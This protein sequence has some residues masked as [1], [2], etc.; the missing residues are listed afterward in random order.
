MAVY[1][2]EVEIEDFEYDEDEEM[3]YYPCP[4]GDRFQISKEELI[5]GEEV[6]TCPS[7]SLIVKVIYDQ[8]AFQAEQDEV[9]P[10]TAE[11]KEQEIV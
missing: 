4:C 2:D 9:Q 6:A 3:Y 1:H 7:C 10:S 5:A 11:T 8:E